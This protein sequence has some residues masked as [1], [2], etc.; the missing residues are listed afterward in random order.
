M[1]RYAFHTYKSHFAC[2]HCRKAFKK[3]AIDDYVGHKGIERE[4][5]LLSAAHSSRKKRA[6]TERE[7]GMTYE[8]ITQRY[9]ADVSVCPQC[10][11]R[12]AAMGLDFRPP[13]QR[14]QEAWEILSR[15]YENGFSF[16]G[17]G[18]S[19]G[20]EPPKSRK[21]V[22]AWLATNSHRSDGEKLLAAILA[23]D[24]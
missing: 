20:Y 13:Q 3:T 24:T 12:M 5:R 7:L 8:Q 6:E 16:R 4:F 2:F 18:C 22:P 19:V 9:L 11:A 10:G 15:L 23:K 21:D 1:C 14:D 17:C